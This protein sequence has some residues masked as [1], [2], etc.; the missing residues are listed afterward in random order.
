MARA[1]WLRTSDLSFDTAF[2]VE[3]GE[4]EIGVFSPLRYGVSERV[5]FSTHPILILVGAVN[6]SLRWRMTPVQRVTLAVNVAADVDLVSNENSLGQR[7]Q[8]ACADCGVPSR[9]QTTA[10]ASVRLGKSWLLSLGVGPAVDFIDFG[11]VRFLAEV[12]GSLIWLVDSRNLVMLHSSGYLSFDGPGRTGMPS[13]QLMYARACNNLNIGL[14]VALGSFGIARSSA[15]R[16]EWFA[17]PVMDIW[18]RF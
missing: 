15:E 7:F 12:H 14:G 2:T 1:E 9:F 6:M 11:Y 8:G 5:Q 4:L 13:T 18:W 16:H 10:T 3:R 17:Y